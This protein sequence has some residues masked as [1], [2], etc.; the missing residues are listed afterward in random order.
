[1]PC[2]ALFLAAYVPDP[3]HYLPVSTHLY[4]PAR[5]PRLPAGARRCGDKP[6]ISMWQHGNRFYAAGINLFRFQ[7]S[8]R[9]CAL[10]GRRARQVCVAQG[11]TNKACLSTACLHETAPRPEEAAA[12][13]L[14]P[15][16]V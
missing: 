8:P 4:L 11:K 5:L 14:L 1:M 12:R 9:A 3:N 13:C 2:K 6:L 15:A 16:I 10:A 7:H